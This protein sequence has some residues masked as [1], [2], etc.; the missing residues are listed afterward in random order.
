MRSLFP[1]LAGM[2]QVRGIIRLIKENNGEIPISKLAEEAE[3]DVDDLLPLIEASKLLGFI[4]MSDSSIKITE[5]GEKLTTS[6]PYRT[7]K[8]SL[9]EVEPFKMI[10]KL[11][12]KKEMTTGEIAASLASKGIVIN[13]NPEL[14]EELIGK[15][16]RGWGM[17]VKLFE[18]AEDGRV[19]KLKQK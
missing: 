1:A 6:N 14:N 9:A 15:M 11:L 17:R 7:I 10:I 4:K 19:W 18:Y 12:S 2:S 5:L 16:L 8:N 13:E 3:E